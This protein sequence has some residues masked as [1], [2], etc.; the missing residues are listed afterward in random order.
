MHFHCVTKKKL[1]VNFKNEKFSSNA[2]IGLAPFSNWSVSTKASVRTPTANNREPLQIHC[3]RYR[4]PAGWDHILLAAVAS[5]TPTEGIPF[6][7]AETMPRLLAL[8]L[9]FGHPILTTKWTQFYGISF[10][11]G[12]NA[13]RLPEC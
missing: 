3:Q 2:K 4:F 6:G 13:Y 5:T 1:F 8:K 7:R 9:R 11:A 10:S 12:K